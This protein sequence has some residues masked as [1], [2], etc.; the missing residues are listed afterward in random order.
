MQVCYYWSPLLSFYPSVT[1]RILQRGK[2]SSFPWLIALMP[3]FLTVNWNDLVKLRQLFSG[4]CSFLNN[5][6][7]LDR[8][9]F[10]LYLVTKNKKLFEARVDK[11]LLGGPVSPL[12]FSPLLCWMFRRVCQ[13][14]P[15]SHD[16]WSLR[17][18]QMGSVILQ[19]TLNSFWFLWK[20]T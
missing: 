12:F 16:R 17:W 9:L 15:S 20:G 2:A 8:M 6:D 19:I 4:D 10:L 5:T 14:Y 13:P 3:K 7:P 1:L 11:Q 18:S